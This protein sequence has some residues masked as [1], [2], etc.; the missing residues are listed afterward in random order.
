MGT[1][2]HLYWKEQSQD[3]QNKQITGWDIRCG[4][5]GYLRAS[6][7]MHQENEVLRRIF[8]D[9]VWDGKPENPK[10]PKCK[11]DGM[12]VA[13]RKWDKK[14]H[15]EHPHGGTLDYPPEFAMLG[16]KEKPYEP[17]PKRICKDCKGNGTEDGIMG[18]RVK[19]DEDKLKELSVLVRIYVGHAVIG[20]PMHSLESP[21]AKRATTMMDMLTRSLTGVGADEIVQGE[22]SDGEIFFK[23]SWANSLIDFFLLGKEMEDKLREP[24][25]YIS[26]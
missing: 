23:I 20:T 13:F 3:E 10:C 2:I 4:D 15:K 11:G 16:T 18:V 14:W 22:V 19:F 24:R 7:G 5:V 12:S 9:D 17:N 25:V 8:G 26:W 21:N 1:D 6:I